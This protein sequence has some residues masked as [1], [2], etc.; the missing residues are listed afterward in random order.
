MAW[1]LRVARLAAI[2][3]ALN[4]DWQGFLALSN[5]SV[6]LSQILVWAYKSSALQLLLLY[7]FLGVTGRKN[8]LAESFAL[9]AVTALLTAVVNLIVPAAGAYEFYAPHRQIFS[10][11]AQDAGM[12]HYKLLLSLRN[13]PVPVLDFANAVGLVT[14]PSFHTTLAIVMAY[15]VRDVSY[16]RFAAPCLRAV[17]IVAALPQGGH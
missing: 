17:V 3:E 11:F 8:R 12:W 9:V 5:S 16:L 14:F 10:N 1:P 7:I 4:F 13:E 2:D 15:G 6:V